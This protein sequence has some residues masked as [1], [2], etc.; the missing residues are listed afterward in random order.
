M[1]NPDYALSQRTEIFVIPEMF[2][3]G[4][5][6]KVSKKWEAIQISVGRIL[7]KSGGGLIGL[8]TNL[9]H[10]K[11]IFLLLMLNQL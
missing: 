7:G 2:Y 9:S 11:I 4:Y 1:I 8:P 5:G 10:P 6:F 3:R